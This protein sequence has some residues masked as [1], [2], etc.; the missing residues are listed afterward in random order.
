MKLYASAAQPTYSGP[1]LG[2]AFHSVNGV[3]E[4]PDSADDVKQLLEFYHAFSTEKPKT[5]APVKEAPKEPV[6]K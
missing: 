5:A 1:L 2:G 6:A 3:V 4:I